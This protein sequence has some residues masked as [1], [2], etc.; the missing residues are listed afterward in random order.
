MR[1]RRA[2]PDGSLCARSDGQRQRLSRRRPSTASS[3][4]LRRHPTTLSSSPICKGRRRGSP[5]A[6]WDLRLLCAALL[7]IQILH[8][9]AG[10]RSRPGAA[11][12]ARGKA[13]ALELG[14]CK[15]TLEVQENNVRGGRGAY[16]RRRFA[17]GCTA[18]RP[19]GRSSRQILEGTC[20]RF[21]ITPLS[22][23]FLAMLAA[24]QPAERPNAVLAGWP[25]RA[26][27]P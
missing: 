17:Q 2:G 6:S 12:A 23:L 1:G 27:R 10:S 22:L 25:S 20:R 18:R 7:N 3:D 26:D 14:C 16:R 5:P 11:P 4:G 21:E 8:P 9:A 19:A 13:K 15:I 24:A